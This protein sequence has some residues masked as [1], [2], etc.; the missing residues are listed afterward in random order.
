MSDAA[1]SL[2]EYQRHAARTA[3]SVL[4]FGA[5]RKVGL[6]CAALGICGE[7]GEVAD[8]VK[9]HV[10]HGVQLDA[11]KLREELG[12]TLWYVALA[13]SVMGWGLEDV[14]AS[15]IAKLRARYPD[16]FS[17]QASIDRKDERP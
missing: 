1:L 17:T 12:D 14:V 8:I 15:N 6:S 3:G 5:D 4:D 16:G 11:A 2:A 10:H 9:K 13:C 7:G